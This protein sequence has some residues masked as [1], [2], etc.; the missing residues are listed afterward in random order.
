MSQDKSR[1]G[2]PKTKK[3]KAV[4]SKNS[5]KHGILS[6]KPV[7]E[8]LER[9]EDWETFRDEI[10]ASLAP[11]GRLEIELAR[12]VA[13]VLWRRNRITPYESESIMLSREEVE[14]N[15]EKVYLL[16]HMEKRARLLGALAAME[17]DKPLHEEDARSIF[18]GLAQQRP[19]LVVYASAGRR[20][21]SEDAPPREHRWTAGE[22]KQVV[23][24]VAEHE[25]VSLAKLFREAVRAAEQEAEKLKNEVTDLAAQGFFESL[26][27][28][29]AYRERT[30]PDE[31]TLEKVQRYEA[32]LTRQLNQTLH[33]LEALQARRQGGS[34][35]LARVD[36]Q[37]LR[38]N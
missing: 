6:P 32:H 8:G 38:E 21:G 30:L 25:G 17:A 3:G 18:A 16:A 7:V 31:K 37:G 36:V 20:F 26:M 4:S 29:R 27:N 24:A 28:N 1:K 22:I 11:V 35:P 5:L 13:S 23:S 34:A 12:N 14:Q 10:L 33:E 19:G 2:G 9:E 15:V